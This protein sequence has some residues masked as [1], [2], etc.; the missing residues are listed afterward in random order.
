MRHTKSLSKIVLICFKKVALL[1]VVQNKHIA[2]EVYLDLM[3]IN[4]GHIDIINR[5]KIQSFRKTIS[6]FPPTSTFQQD[7]ISKVIFKDNVWLKT[8]TRQ[9]Y[10][11]IFVTNPGSTLKRNCQVFDKNSDLIIQMPRSWTTRLNRYLISSNPIGQDINDLIDETNSQP[12]NSPMSNSKDDISNN[13]CPPSPNS[14]TSY[15]D[16]TLA[17]STFG[18]YKPFDLYQQTKPVQEIVLERMMKLRSGYKTF[19]RW[20]NNI[21][22]GDKNKLCTHHDIFI[23]QLKCKYISIALKVALENLDKSNLNWL[24][25]CKLAIEKVDELEGKD[26]DEEENP[27]IGNY[28]KTNSVVCPQTIQRWHHDF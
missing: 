24:D 9:R 13:T 4:Y 5:L 27:H 11:V 15:W 1:D 2:L 17:R 23:I 8:G 22:D 20:K 25:C 28:S 16:S 14:F 7:D 6:S 19:N 21:L 26:S 12:Q 3:K 10:V 18:Y